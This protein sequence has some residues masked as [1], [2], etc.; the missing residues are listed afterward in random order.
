MIPPN[1]RHAEAPQPMYMDAPSSLFCVAIVRTFWKSEMVTAAD[2]QTG[3]RQATPATMQ[4]MPPRISTLAMEDSFF[5]Q[6]LHWPPTNVSIIPMA[7]ITIAMMISARAACK[8][9]VRLIIESWILHCICPVLCIT[10]FIHKPSQTIWAVVMLAPMYEVTRH[11]GM[12]QQT[13]IPTKPMKHRVWPDTSLAILP[14]V[15]SQSKAAVGLV[16]IHE[17]LRNKQEVMACLTQILIWEE[18][19][20][21]V[22]FNP[23]EQDS[24]ARFLKY[25]AIP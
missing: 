20:R 3:I 2:Q 23:A 7:P 18:S 5:R 19:C 1:R 10:Q 25:A 17:C 21:A 9:W 8:S 14:M 12:P 4:R 15:L 24:K 22:C 6:L 11:N 13:H 16:V